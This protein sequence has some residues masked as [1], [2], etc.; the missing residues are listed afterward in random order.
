MVVLREATATWRMDYTSAELKSQCTCQ[1]RNQTTTATISTLDLYQIHS[2]VL[3]H[4]RKG[5]LKQLTDFDKIYTAV[6]ATKF[7]TKCY[8][9]HNYFLNSVLI[10]TS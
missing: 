2:S 10:M 8:H 1:I 7:L 5:E 4:D 3:A 6:T 9:L